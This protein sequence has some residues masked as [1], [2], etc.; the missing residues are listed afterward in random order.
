M[1]GGTTKA[2]DDVRGFVVSFGKAKQLCWKGA[3]TSTHESSLIGAALMQPQ[4]ALHAHRVRDI[5]ITAGRKA[6]SFVDL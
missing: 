6:L 1:N 5:R 3:P 4:I 2:P